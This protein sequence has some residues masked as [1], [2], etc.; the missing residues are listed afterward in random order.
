MIIV[1]KPPSTK[2]S[3]TITAPMVKKALI[4]IINKYGTQTYYHDRAGELDENP[5]GACKYV[6]QNKGKTVPGCLVGAALIEEFDCDPN[7]FTKS[8]GDGW[9]TALNQKRIRVALTKINVNGYTHITYDAMRLLEDAQSEQD[10]RMSWGYSVKT[11]I[12]V[13]K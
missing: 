11:A 2:G 7:E 5:S 10:R 13:S 8:P 1:Q 4:K 6:F 9:E 3:K 12:G